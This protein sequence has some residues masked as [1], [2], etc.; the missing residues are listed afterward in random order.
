M[1]LLLTKPVKISLS[2][3][4]C[5]ALCGSAAHVYSKARQR[6]MPI[7]LNC[8][9]VICLKCLLFICRQ[10]QRRKSSYC[11]SSLPSW[12]A[13]MAMQFPDTVVCVC[14]WGGGSQHTFHAETPLLFPSCVS[15]GEGRGKNIL[16]RFRPA[17]LLGI[18]ITY[19]VVQCQT[20]VRCLPFHHSCR[21]RWRQEDSSPL[22]ACGADRHL[23][24]LHS[25]GR[26]EPARIC[27]S[28]HTP[29]ASRLGVHH[30]LWR[31]ADV[32]VHG[33][34]GMQ[35]DF[36]LF[37][38]LCTGGVLHSKIA[39]PWAPTPCKLPVCCMV[40]VWHTV[41]G[42]A[43]WAYTACAWYRV[44]FAATAAKPGWSN[45]PHIVVGVLPFAMPHSDTAVLLD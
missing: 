23:H 21:Q 34:R 1:R 31:P 20:P 13:H 45:P 17:V 7:R 27:W 3:W 11:R 22:P 25:G 38:S 24:H 9:L 28:H 33:E 12:S 2:A 26:T 36:A 29:C 19:T 16:L 5:A 30:N 32:P 35:E 37:G 6:S 15:V 8:L 14:V 44:H 40:F 4:Q 39:V 10:G 18:S 42:C 41:F 43:V